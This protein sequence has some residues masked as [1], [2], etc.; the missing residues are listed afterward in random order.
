MTETDL[1]LLASYAREKADDVFAE[2]VRRHLKGGD[3]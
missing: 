1:E 2:I 3:I